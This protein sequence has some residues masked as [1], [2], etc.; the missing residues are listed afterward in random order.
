MAKRSDSGSPSE[1]NVPQSS[2]PSTTVSVHNAAHL[3]DNKLSKCVL[4]TKVLLATALIAVS[5]REGRTVTLRALI[6]Q[7]SE[8]TLMSE[9]ALNVSQL[10]WTA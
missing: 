3:S 9:S 10:K 4:P 7:G 2:S 1:T 6:D 8:R 5:T